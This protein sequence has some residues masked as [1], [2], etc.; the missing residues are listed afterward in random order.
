MLDVAMLSLVARAGEVNTTR[1]AAKPHGVNED[2]MCAFCV[3]LIA[4]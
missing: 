2:G 1:L 3:G 4:F